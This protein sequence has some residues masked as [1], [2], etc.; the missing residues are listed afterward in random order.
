MWT[1]QFFSWF[2]FPTAFFFSLSQVCRTNPAEKGR[3]IKI[4]LALLQSSSTAV[5]YECAV[6]LVS[7]S[8]APSAIRAAANCYCQLL[9]SQSDNNVKLIV[10][11]R[12][13]EL[14]EKHRDVMQDVLMDILRALSS[15]NMDIRKKTLDIA[16]D[17]ITS[18]NIDE[19]RP[20]HV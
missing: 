17:L 16:M 11:E 1:R 13:Q 8:Q 2:F 6:T 19:V 4:I 15:P 5:V 10:L 9:V 12:L 14:K 18:R 20:R 7:L 3:Y